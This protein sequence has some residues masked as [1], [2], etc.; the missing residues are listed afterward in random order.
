M[1]LLFSCWSHVFDC[2]GAFG[3]VTADDAMT[4]TLERMDGRFGPRAWR[5]C[6]ATACLFRRWLVQSATFVCLLAGCAFPKKAIVHLRS[7]CSATFEFDNS[8]FFF[9]LFKSI[10]LNF[11]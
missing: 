1:R 9:Y 3:R 4:S 11:L 5:L 10:D 2:V 6:A 7:V 8:R